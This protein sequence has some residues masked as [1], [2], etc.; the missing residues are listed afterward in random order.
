[1]RE[2]IEGIGP[3][4]TIPSRIYASKMVVDLLKGGYQCTFYNNSRNMN[5][6]ADAIKARVSLDEVSTN[7]E[8]LVITSN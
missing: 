2:Y 4:T 7:Y 6:A 1:M 8:L 3:N 5:T